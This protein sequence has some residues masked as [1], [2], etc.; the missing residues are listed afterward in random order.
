MEASLAENIERR[1]SARRRSIEEH[2]IT[3]ARVKPGHDV[4]LIDISLGGALVEGARRLLPGTAV[5]LYLRAGDLCGAVRGRVLRCS[6][7]SVK[8]TIVWYRGAIGFDGDIRWFREG[9]AHTAVRTG[10]A[11]PTRHEWERVTHSAT[12]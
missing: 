4:D 2:G 12:G 1:R 11:L 6:V 8:P 5:E 3:A 9:E 10:S 7:V